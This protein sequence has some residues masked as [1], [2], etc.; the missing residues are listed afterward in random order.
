LARQR[1][2]VKIPLMSQDLEPK[3]GIH[4]FGNSAYAAKPPMSTS[5]RGQAHTR[6]NVARAALQ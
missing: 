5:A 2:P 3:T 4:S 1:K 6:L